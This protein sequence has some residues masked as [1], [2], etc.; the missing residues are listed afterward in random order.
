MNSG[1]FLKHFLYI[2]VFNT[3]NT[4]E[5]IINFTATMLQFLDSFIYNFNII[6]LLMFLS[7]LYTNMYKYMKKKQ[8]RIIL[9]LMRND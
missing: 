9:L 3:T 2:F 1:F 6:L 5:Y 7:K 4:N 8:H